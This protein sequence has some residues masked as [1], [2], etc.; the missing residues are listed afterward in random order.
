MTGDG[1]QQAQLGMLGLLV[2]A[3]LASVATRLSGVVFMFAGACMV[4]GARK[5]IEEPSGALTASGIRLRN[6]LVVVMGAG[7]AAIG[8]GLLVVHL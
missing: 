4:L 7:A 5:G 6:Q 3:L 1:R 8:V 2:G